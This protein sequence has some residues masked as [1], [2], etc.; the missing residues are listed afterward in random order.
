MIDA[1][2]KQIRACRDARAALRP[3]LAGTLVIR[4][5]IN[6]DGA[7]T[8]VT[9]ESDLPRDNDPALNRCVEIVVQGIAFPELDLAGGI[10]VVHR[11]ELPP[12]R[13]IRGRTCSPA[14]HLPVGLRR[15]IWL[16]R[17]VQP[18]TKS[19][20]QQY[21]EAKKACELPTWSDK[22]VFLELVLAQLGDGVQRVELARRLAA[23]GEEDAAELLRQEA[24]RRARDPREL[25][26]VRLA[27][28]GDEKL[29]IPAFRKQY[30]AAGD[31]AARLAVVHK[32]LRIAPHDAALRR[33]LFVLLEATGKKDALVAEVL[34]ARQDPLSDAA[35]LAEG[36]AALRRAG[37]EAEARRAYGELVE[38]APRDPA[39]RAYLGDRL[40]A[41]G[42]FDDATFAYA[43][44]EDLAPDEP[45]TTLRLAL[46][47]AGARRLDVT[48]RM[49]S[50]LA[51][52]GGRA[53][54][55][56]LGELGARLE[57]VLLA[58]ALA[59]AELPAADRD[60]L[61]R[62]TLEIPWQR[63]GAIVLVRT[64]R[65]LRPVEAVVQRGPANARETMTPD[66]TAPGLGIATFLLEPGDETGVVITLRRSQALQPEAA[67]PVR[68]DVVR[69][70]DELAQGKLATWLGT[71][72][73][74]GKKVEISWEGGKLVQKR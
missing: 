69:A 14:S 27:L 37:F 12:V 44:L 13:E 70:G 52:T 36:A 25:W 18:S 55:T 38:R 32:F 23:A 8:K 19:I 20:D 3:D 62:Q 39:A 6:A 35:L 30:R 68:V 26:A 56:Q 2:G 34:R 4:V 61:A 67:V 7:V 54:D 16:S 60:R 1:A 17:L 49:L 50:R 42:W 28:V 74:D 40:R 59:S 41:E 57:A 45:A 46:S 71:L 5:K 43:A 10:E 22:R 53:A 64:P 33:R 31:N 63:A 65:L 9:V 73:A 24:M 21:I 48:T 47:H 51:V 15:G 11:F 58:D 72:E 29:P 66:L